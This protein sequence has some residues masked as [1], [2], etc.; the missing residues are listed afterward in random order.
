MF[1]LTDERLGELGAKITV[2][3]IEQQPVVWKEA[4][5]NYYNKKIEIDAFLAKIANKH[6]KVRVIFTGAGT[7]AF[8]GDTVMP[9]LKSKV[10]ETKW[11]LT[12]TPTTDL[13]SNPRQYF[14]KEIPTLLVSYSRSGNSPES[15]A[16]VDLGNQLVKDFYQLTITCAKDGKVAINAAGDEKNLLLL[17]PSLS[18]DK[19]F[20]MTSSFTCMTLTT[21]LVFDTLTDEEKSNAVNIIADMA[22][23]AMSKID[24]ISEMISQDFKRVIYLG[25]GSLAA[26]TREASLKILELTAGKIATLFDSS[27]GFRH[28]P[29]SFVDEESLIFV[30]MSNDPY[31]RLYDLDMINEIYKDNIAQNVYSITTDENEEFAGN[32]FLYPKIGKDIPEGY[33][34]LAY[35]VFAQ[36]VS[37]MAAVKVKNTPDTPSATGTVNRVVKGVIIHEFV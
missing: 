13:L 12:S 22:E 28:G 24:V 4:L 8:V 35:V 7:S 2:R 37:V 11:E 26:L 5:E 23:D 6:N 25:S 29:K 9:Y 34:A 19:G 32:K 31:T 15:M 17:Q 20:A 33:L 1:T 16:A 18:N 14:N 36:I 21:L 3:E 10:D 30:F 27:L